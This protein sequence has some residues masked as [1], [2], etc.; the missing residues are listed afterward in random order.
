MTHDEI[1][2]LRASSGALR[3]YAISTRPASTATSAV[4][5]DSLSRL[6]RAVTSPSASST[7][8]HDYR[9][10]RESWLNGETGQHP[11]HSIASVVRTLYSINE[12][13]RLRAG[14]ERHC[15]AAHRGPP[16][17]PYPLPRNAFAFSCPPGLMG[18]S[19]VE[20]SVARARV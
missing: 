18:A 19:M 20:P 16:T 17:H 11:L 6:D 14:T 4:F 12:N 1:I 10:R 3:L 9:Q 13:T 7:R 15:R 5:K 8:F 2:M